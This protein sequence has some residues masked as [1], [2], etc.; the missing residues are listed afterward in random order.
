MGP[1]RE[2]WYLSGPNGDTMDALTAIASRHSTRSFTHQPV[3]REQL[4]AIVDAGRHAPT[5]RNDQP[6]Q[7]VVVAEAATRKRLAELTEGG[8]AFLA[9]APACI[10]VFCKEGKYFLEDGCNAATSMLIAATALGL[11]SCWVAGDKKPYANAVQTLL[12]APEGMRLVALLAIGH[13]T[14]G[15]SPTPKRPLADV[16]RWERF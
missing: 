4:E 1:G 11:Q 13:A 2:V 15:G 5:A 3:S 8:G 6:W 10:A 7:F 16:L 12:F 9:D 14:D